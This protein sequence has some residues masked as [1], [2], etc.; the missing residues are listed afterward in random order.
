MSEQK[1]PA[2]AWLL[3]GGSQ[4]NP[5]GKPNQDALYYT[6]HPLR[7]PSGWPSALAIVCDGVGGLPRY[8]SYLP[9]VLRQ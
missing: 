1:T 6:P 2:A 3:A 4:P 5:K 8:Q 9:L 7:T